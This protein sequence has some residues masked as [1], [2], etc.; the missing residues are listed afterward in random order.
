[1]KKIFTL[2]IILLFS[3][4]VL[5]ASFNLESY[6]YLPSP[7]SAGDTFDLILQVKNTSSQDAETVKVSI[8]LDWPF[9]ALGETTKTIQ[10][11]RANR[12]SI[13]EFKGLKIN[14]N[15]ETGTYELNV[16]YEDSTGKI[17]KKNTLEITVLAETPKIKL[18][19]SSTKE[20][21]LG[22]KKEIEF[23][24][25]NI[26]GEPAKNIIIEFQEDRTIT[27]TGEIIERE[28]I[29]LGSSAVYLTEIKSGEEKTV[30]FTLS[31]NNNAELKNYSLP[32]N[33]TFNDSK[34]NEFSSIVYAGLKTTA[35][36]ELNIL[37]SS[38][39][40]LY[41]GAENEIFFDIF[42]TGKAGALYSVIELKSDLFEF[43]KTKTFIGTLEADDFDSF[44]TKIKIPANTE[45]GN[46][47]ITALFLYKDFGTEE[48]TTEKKMNVKIIP[49]NEISGK[50]NFLG[51]IIG[52]ITIL[53]ALIGL[54][55][56]GKKIYSK[57]KK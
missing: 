49:L 7:V 11:I 42:N 31:A 43:E 37:I 21:K 57:I 46:Y 38:L 15:A 56:V 18:I 9:I 47:E 5:S 20:I 39:E 4:S 54:F 27:S 24:F 55:F 34:N 3:L 17:N 35:T 28:I 41:P 25:K 16:T 53:F 33:I 14:P 22:E 29:P 30:S 13:I 52:L 1:M 32:I 45:P 40:P 44:K 23:T 50:Q 36:P 26:G 6:N 12:I 8:E 51:D 19:N 10:A 2:T 48:K